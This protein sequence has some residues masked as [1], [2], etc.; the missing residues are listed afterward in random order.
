MSDFDSVRSGH[1]GSVH[2]TLT[3]CH[4]VMEAVYTWRQR[5]LSGSVYT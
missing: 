3:V 4:Q 5:R 2:L 1:G